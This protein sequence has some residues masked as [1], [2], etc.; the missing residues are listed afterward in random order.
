MSVS[1]WQKW[2]PDVALGAVVAFFG[3]A[4]V[5]GSS[6]YIFDDER[7]ALAFI[8]V[9]MGVAAACARHAPAA[10]LAVVWLV[11]GLQVLTGTTVMLTQISVVIV[12]F[13]TARWGRP[14]TVVASGLSIPLA[15]VAAVWFLDQGYT[16]RALELGE[17]SRI[18]EDAYQ[19]GDSW[20]IGAGLVGLAILAMPW[21]AGLAFRY[22]DR[23]R[24]SRVSQVEA[25]AERDQAEEIARLR[26]DQARLA[27]DVHDVVGHSLAVIL[28]QAE[29][30][31][32]LDEV[33]TQGLKRT[34]NNI[35]TSARTSL[36]DV[37]QVLASTSGTA[38]PRAGKVDLDGLVEGVRASGHEVV[39]T[40]V[41]V[42]QPMP[43]ELEV[44][45]FRVLQEMLTNAIKH[46]PRDRPVRV[47]RHWEG[48]LRIEVQ[49]ALDSVSD[50]TQPLAVVVDPPTPGGQGIDG[51]R[52]RLDSVGG[53]LDVRRRLDPPTFTATAWVPVRAR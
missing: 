16:M 8:A 11:C 13:G 21:L 34:M 27:R 22:A 52:R 29:S 6:R 4:E 51:M 1:W 36:D 37:R 47:E 3:L 38:A 12:G 35:A 32:Y 46:G 40:E 43:P 15:A 10:A 23:A 18:I 49:N 20:Q 31:Q 53:R 19:Y 17:V 50:E 48:D 42:P 14:A 41:G 2:G 44:V 33:D 45:A 26:E 5:L 9:G 7:T 28:A 39:S 25:E 24:Q 30:A